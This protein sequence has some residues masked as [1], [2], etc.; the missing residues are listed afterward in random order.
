MCGLEQSPVGLHELEEGTLFLSLFVSNLLLVK[1]V[2]KIDCMKRSRG[3][4]R[5]RS[6]TFTKSC[7]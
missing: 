6:Y 7:M 5:A 1:L 4:K 2:K 3:T